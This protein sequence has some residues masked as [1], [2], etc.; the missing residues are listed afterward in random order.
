[1]PRAQQPADRVNQESGLPCARWNGH[2][3]QVRLHYLVLAFLFASCATAPTEQPTWHLTWSDEFDHDGLPDPSHWDYEDGKIRNGEAQFYTREARNA[4]IENGHLILEAHRQ[5]H[6]GSAYTAASLHTKGKASFSFSRVE[7]RAKLPHGRGVWPAIWM[8]GNDWPAAHWPACGEIDILEFV[9]FEPGV[10]HS[11]VHSDG[12]NHMRG[13]GRGT[14]IPL[15]DASETFHTYA[16]EWDRERM[17]FSI[18]GGPTFAVDNDHTGAASW[19]FDG[20]FF[21]LLNFA[22][23]GSWGGQK[24]IDESVFPQRFEIDWVRVYERR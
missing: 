2:A 1:M 13:N 16:V 24:G 6:D 15:A 12:Y 14:R 20:P 22:V 10:V 11:N 21:L 19:P 5:D 9:G 7:V 17:V 3:A 8:L 4:R 18:D 23:G